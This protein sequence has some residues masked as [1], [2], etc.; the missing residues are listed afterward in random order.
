MTATNG[1]K[2]DLGSDYRDHYD[3][4]S[5]LLH[6]LTVALVVIL[7]ALAEA[8][9]FLE[10][11]TPLRKQLQSLHISLG[12]MLTIVVMFRLS[13]RAVVG[14]H[15]PPAATGVKEGAAKTMHFVLYVLLIVQIFTGFVFRWAQAESFMFFGLFPVQFSTVKNKALDDAV[16]DIHDIIAWFII[17]LMVFHAAAALIHHYLLKDNVLRRMLPKSGADR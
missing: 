12:I 3:R 13:W 15:L 6:W 16:G 2:P 5:I 11:G 17:V 14:R 9:D 7:F 10:H 4:M 1:L 8:W